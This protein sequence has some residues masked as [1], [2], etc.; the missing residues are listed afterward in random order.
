[1]KSSV[2]RRG[3]AERQAEELLAGH[4]EIDRR[5]DRPAQ[6]L[7]LVDERISR[8]RP[9]DDVEGQQDHLGHDLDRL[10]SVRGAFPSLRDALHRSLDVLGELGEGPHL[11]ERLEELAL[12][13]PQLPG[14]GREPI[15][16][17][18]SSPV[19]LLG[20]D[21][22]PAH[23]DVMHVIRVGDQVKAL[24]PQPGARDVAVGAPHPLK[25]GKHSVAPQ[26]GQ[27]PD[28]GEPARSRRAVAARR[29]FI[30]GENVHDRLSE[31]S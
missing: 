19:S 23:E 13:F 20:I 9:G 17:Q 21:V 26:L 2:G 3:Q 1:V 16:D 29:A 10:A 12:L 31:C 11:E 15:S 14:A 30:S 24:A 6:Q 4:D 28:H 22:P 7:A 25:E 18:R 8:H 27:A 5:A